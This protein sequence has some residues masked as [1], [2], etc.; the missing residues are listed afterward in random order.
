MRLTVSKSLFATGSYNLSFSVTSY[1]VHMYVVFFFE[2]EDIHVQISVVQ[3]SY[4]I[5][6]VLSS[7][8]Q[9]PGFR[10]HSNTLCAA[11]MPGMRPNCG[12]FKLSYCSHRIKNCRMYNIS[13]GAIGGFW[14]FMVLNKPAS[15]FLSF[16]LLW[17]TEPL[18]YLLTTGRKYYSC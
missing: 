16:S 5:L 13:V 18:K 2:E 12:S 10:L 9:V 11:E 8:L 3:F 14:M 7:N 17:T 1:S 15:A 6:K 4:R